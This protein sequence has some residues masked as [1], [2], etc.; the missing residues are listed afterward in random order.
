MFHAIKYIKIGLRFKY[1]TRLKSQTNQL[2][3][4]SVYRTTII[5]Y[6]ILSVH[7]VQSK[8]PWDVSQN[9]KY[10]DMNEVY[11]DLRH[12]HYVYIKLK[13][14]IRFATVARGWQT[15][16]PCECVN[17]ALLSGH[18]QQLLL[19]TLTPSSTAV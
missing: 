6:T 8:F 17:N 18:L 3:S 11:L 19:V 12:S 14:A 1:N 15:W 9:D 4:S 5:L 2:N 16:W 13:N 10:V 7:T